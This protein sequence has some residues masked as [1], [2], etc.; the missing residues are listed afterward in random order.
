[1]KS[2]YA[3]LEYGQEKAKQQVYTLLRWNMHYVQRSEQLLDEQRLSGLGLWIAL[4]MILSS[5][6]MMVDLCLLCIQ[7]LKVGQ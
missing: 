7:F 3:L 6:K 5:M 1:M 2:I 4:P